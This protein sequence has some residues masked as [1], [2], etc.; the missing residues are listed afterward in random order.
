MGAQT[1]LGSYYRAFAML[2][3]SRIHCYGLSAA[4]HPV[5]YQQLRF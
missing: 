1:T 3:D 5:G 2:L 4:R